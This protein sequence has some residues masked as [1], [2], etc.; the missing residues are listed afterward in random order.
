MV[1]DISS[2]SLKAFITAS[3]LP[4]TL[5]SPLFED[6]PLVLANDA[7]LG[8]TGYERDEV[9]GRNCRFLQ[10]PATD[11]AARARL[12][13]AI[14]SRSDVLVSIT[15]YRRDGTSFENLVFIVPIFGESGTLLYLLGS[16]CDVTLPS[17][18]LTAL[19]HAQVLDE[20]IDANNP[21][22]ARRD[23]LRVLTSTPCV[24]AARGLISTKAGTRH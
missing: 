23:N 5:A 22:L 20:A 24:E 6:C 18:K 13:A 11:V 3:P 2:K 7:F 1:A 14:E 17:R 4:M 16:Q 9:I 12:R 21:R 10:G 8:L 19:E 15:N